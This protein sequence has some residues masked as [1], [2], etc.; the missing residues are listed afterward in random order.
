MTFTKQQKWLIVIVVLIVVLLALSK[1]TPNLKTTSSNQAN[2]GSAPSVAMMDADFARMGGEMVAMESSDTAIEDEAGSEQRIIKRAEFELLVDSV[3]G[4]QA[5]LEQVT[6]NFG[7]F[8]QDAAVYERHDKTM[9]GNAT[10][11]LEADRFEEALSE[12]RGLA[13]NI[14]RERITG[15]D[16]T[17]QFTDLEAQLRNARAEENAYLALLARAG[18]VSDLLE[19]QRELSKVRGTIERFEGRMKYLSN[20]TDLATITISLSEK[21]SIIAPTNDFRFVDTLKEALQALVV[22]FQSVVM[23]IVWIVVFSV[24]VV[25]PIMI[26]A[27]IARK[28]WRRS[29]K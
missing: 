16:V 15:Q 18:S 10:L 26:L 1:T 7:G 9:S 13:I 20:Q 6:K 17:E 2:Y 25:L 14:E 21:P 8:V 22:T 5:S 4:T 24:G 29:K 12:I 3:S 19:V 23:A 28:L 11:R 27:W